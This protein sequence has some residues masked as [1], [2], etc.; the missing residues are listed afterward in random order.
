MVKTKQKFKLFFPKLKLCFELLRMFSWTATVRQRQ[1]EMAQLQ[2]TCTV[3]WWRIH[4][5]RRSCSTL[6]PLTTPHSY[7]PLLRQTVVVVVIQSLSTSAAHNPLAFRQ[8]QM[9]CLPL[10]GKHL[11]MLTQTLWPVFQ[12]P[13][14][15]PPV[16]AVWGRRTVRLPPVLAWTRTWEPP[17]RMACPVWWWTMEE[18]LPTTTTAMSSTMDFSLQQQLMLMIIGRH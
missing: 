10:E 12:A 13:P 7:Q 11:V 17:I 3:R 5:K 6:P 8:T 16:M 18:V 1:P 4:S 15:P 9:A 2:F 14:P